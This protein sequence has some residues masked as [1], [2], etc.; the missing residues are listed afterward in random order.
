MGQEFLQLE[1]IPKRRSKFDGLAALMSL[2]GLGDYSEDEYNAT[3]RL[4]NR[5]EL[6]DPANDPTSTQ[7]IFAQYR[8][9]SEN[10]SRDKEAAAQA[11]YDAYTPPA[12]EPPSVTLAKRKQAYADASAAW[13]PTRA[14]ANTI[15]AAYSLGEE[16]AL[17]GFGS[18]FK[19]A[20]TPPKALRRFVTPPRQIRKVATAVSNFGRKA[21]RYAGAAEFTVLTGGFAGGM[22]NKLFGLKGSE[23]KIAND[24]NKITRVAAIAA[25]TYVGGSAINSAMSQSSLEKLA[26]NMGKNYPTL[27]K[28][29]IGTAE[30]FGKGTIMGK[31]VGMIGPTLIKDAA[32]GFVMKLMHKGGGGGDDL[33]AEQYNASQIP[34]ATYNAI[35]D[36]TPVPLGEGGAFFNQPQ[37]GGASETAYE[38]N[39]DSS[40]DD[41][42]AVA[43]TR[44]DPDQAA[45]VLSPG[46]AQAA[47]ESR[48]KSILDDSDNDDSVKDLITKGKQEPKE[49]ETG[50]DGLPS[51]GAIIAYNRRRAGVLPPRKRVG[52]IPARRRTY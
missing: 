32:S 26:F 6:F 30:L 48:L 33:V 2:A 15:F 31:V 4:Y 28:G 49:D 18:W 36:A 21:L 29:I 3:N 45:E 27:T 34:P 8:S 12:G 20:F 47:H 43:D 9:G 24:M 14:G 41:G 5:K 39:D 40:E 51:L 46:V 25:A 10:D 52:I 42:T 1:G 17:S 13:K 44:L 11:A 19:H 50:V 23:Q 35:P 22:E 16:I 38:S 37:V 7:D